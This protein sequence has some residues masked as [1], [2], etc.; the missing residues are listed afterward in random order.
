M[1]C[2]LHITFMC[3]IKNYVTRLI[4]MSP[5]CHLWDIFTLQEHDVQIWTESDLLEIGKYLVIFL[6]KFGCKLN[7]SIYFHPVWSNML[8]RIRFPIDQCFQI[9][10]KFDV[11]YKMMN[12]VLFLPVI[13]SLQIL[14]TKGRK[15]VQVRCSALVL[16][17]WTSLEIQ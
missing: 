10:C 12:A 3:Y 4:I 2:V 5:S 14:L 6:T 11:T 8:N 13:E 7:H 1:P 17:L 9:L 15:F 16:N